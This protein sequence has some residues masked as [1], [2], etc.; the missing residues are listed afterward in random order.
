[1]IHKISSVFHTFKIFRT[2]KISCSH[3]HAS[4][5]LFTD[6]K[7]TFEVYVPGG[8][9]RIL[10]LQLA[11]KKRM[12]TEEFLQGFKLEDY[13]LWNICQD[14]I[15]YNKYLLLSV[16]GREYFLSDG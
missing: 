2:E 8:K 12:T 3:N 11:G 16:N 14:T 10:E 5:E 15:F 6:G 7:K 4:G 13:H 1:M 9:L